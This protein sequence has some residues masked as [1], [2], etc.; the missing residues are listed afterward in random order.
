VDTFLNLLALV[1][2]IIGV[3]AFAAA[4]TWL[5]V[6]ISPTRE[7]GEQPSSTPSS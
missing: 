7:K 1:L 2:F 3:V 5:T 6:K 4:L